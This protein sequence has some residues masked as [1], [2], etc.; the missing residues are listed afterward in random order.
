MRNL[1][2]ARE[3]LPLS[4]V[5]GT[6]FYPKPMWIMD[7]SCV[8]LHVNRADLNPEMLCQEAGHYRGLTYITSLQE[9]S[10]LPYDCLDGVGDSGSR[11]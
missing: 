3:I 7:E 9:V 6:Q 1:V 10:G 4:G 11:A 8:C 5:S 2:S